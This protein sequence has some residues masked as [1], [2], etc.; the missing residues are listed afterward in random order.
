MRFVVDLPK[1]PLNKFVRYEAT[2]L[3][4]R[5]SIVIITLAKSIHNIQGEY[6]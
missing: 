3:I 5:D 6:S 2:A 1:R 4:F